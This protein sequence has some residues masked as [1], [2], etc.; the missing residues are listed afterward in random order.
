[1][2][3]PLPEGLIAIYLRKGDRIIAG[4]I[5]CKPLSFRAVA[6]FRLCVVDVIVE[7]NKV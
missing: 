2:E 7:F 3:S 6:S 1:M 5:T 4:F